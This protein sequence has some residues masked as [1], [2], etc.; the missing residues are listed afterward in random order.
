M[1]LLWGLLE[2]GTMRT[3]YDRLQHMNANFLFVNHAEIDKTTIE[4]NIA[5]SPKYFLRDN[6]EKIDLDGATSAYLRP[7]NFRDFAQF[8]NASDSSILEKNA[9]I[10][11]H[12][13]H[14]WAENSGARI[15]NKPSAEATNHSKLFQ[16]RYILA[17]GFL[18][19]DS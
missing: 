9:D 12:L 18:V 13:I 4:F 6:G 1:I 14:S 2:D 11:H 8:N 17:S 3:V 7:Y 19:P 5:P 10:F 15:L 16:S